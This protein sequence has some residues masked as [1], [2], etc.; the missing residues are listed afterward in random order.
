V[1]FVAASGS[2]GARYVITGLAPAAQD[3]LVKSLALQATRTDANGGVDVKKPRIGLYNS[4][5]SMDSGWT[6]WILEQ[7]DIEYTKILPADFPGT[8]ALK[9]RFDVILLT[10][11]GGAAFGGGGGRGGRGGGRGGAAAP[12]APA[13]PNDRPKL[14]EDFVRAGGTLVTFNR[15]SMQAANALQF[16]ITSAT[17]GKT[18]TEFFVGG[19]VL[20]INTDPTER[21]M[22]GT[23]EQM[24]VFF[25]SGPVFDV[26]ASFK[27]TVLAKYQDTGSPLMSGYLL[28]EKFMNGKAAA[29]DIDLGAGHVVMLG[30]RP[31]WRGQTMGAFKVIFNALLSSK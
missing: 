22:A 24:G 5:S 8:G 2:T 1:R 31:Q 17:A 20:Q 23:T 26:P 9:D 21:V 29:L 25:D 15:A 14:I 19:S 7:Y 6:R 30:F 28:G 4:P 18:R 27:A 3:A 10:D 11:D 13:A 12:A 16:P